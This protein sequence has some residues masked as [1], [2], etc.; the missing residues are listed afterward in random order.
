MIHSVR[1]QEN[2]LFNSIEIVEIIV[3]MQRSHI[4]AIEQLPS[5]YLF[6]CPINKVNSMLTWLFHGC[7]WLPF[8]ASGVSPPHGILSADDKFLM[9]CHCYYRLCPT[10]GLFPVLPLIWLL[11][12]SKYYHFQWRSNVFIYT[13]VCRW[14]CASATLIFERAISRT[15][16]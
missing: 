12:L 1:L 2:I 4:H 7:L 9:Q 15:L 6:F 8:P 5:P 11:F 16:E 10:R 13:F 14:D 3:S